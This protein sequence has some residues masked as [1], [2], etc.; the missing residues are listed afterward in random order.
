[1]GTRAERLLEGQEDTPVHAWLAVVRSYERLL[2]GDFGALG[3]GPVEPSTWARAAIRRPRPSDGSRRRA[4]SS[5]RARSRAVSTLLNEAAVAAVSGELDPLSTGVVYCEVV[6]ALQALAQYDLA[7][8][9]TQAMERW[10]Q[11][12][13]SG[14]STD[15]AACTAPRSS[16]CVGRCLE[17]EQEAL[18]ACEELRPYLRREFGW[19]L[20]ELGRIRLR[21]GDIQ[22]AEE[23]FLA[24]HQA[25]WDPQPGLALVHSGPG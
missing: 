6:C 3:S 2:S 19:P 24:A 16:G 22:G 23:A 4:A 25:G 9:W 12:Q 18:R 14:V 21:K 1:M 15:A 5:C 7:E 8:E 20:T 11:G 17:A 13:P 10:R